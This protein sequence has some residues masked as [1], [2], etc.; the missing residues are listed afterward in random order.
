M[1]RL[2]LPAGS[3]VDGCKDFR[4]ENSHNFLRAISSIPDSLSFPVALGR[5]GP[6][7]ERDSPIPYTTSASSGN[8]VAPGG[9]PGDGVCPS[10]SSLQAV[11]Q[12]AYDKWAA[13]A[14]ETATYGRNDMFN[15]NMFLRFGRP[16]SKT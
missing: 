9:Y 12:T 11:F 6:V 14:S 3:P 7:Q 8:D 5:N 16:L 1:E 4:Y 13:A 2:R 10:I 15:M